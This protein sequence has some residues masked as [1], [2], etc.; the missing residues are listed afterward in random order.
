[1]FSP[2]SAATLMALGALPLAGAPAQRVSRALPACLALPLSADIRPTYEARRGGWVLEFRDTPLR[3]ILD[4]FNRC[5]T[6]TFRL[7]SEDLGA[8]K[9]TGKWSLHESTL[10]A[11]ALA[12]DPTYAIT[13]DDRSIRIDARWEKSPDSTEN[14]QH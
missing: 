12:H 8:I 14:S 3:D 2:L 1:M 10:F 5:N 13:V 11:D 7:L 4:I 9:Y 6:V